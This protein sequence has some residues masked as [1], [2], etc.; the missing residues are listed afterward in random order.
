LLG[1]VADVDAV[2]EQRQPC[3]L[4]VGEVEVGGGLMLST[5]ATRA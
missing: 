1:E 3:P 4:L 2:G 5:T